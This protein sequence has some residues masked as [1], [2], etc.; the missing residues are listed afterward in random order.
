PLPAAV[1]EG[2][3]VMDL[4]WIDRDEVARTGLH[5]AAPAVGSLR[6]AGDQADAELVVRVAAER[7]PRIG[8]DGFGAG[9]AARYAPEVPARHL[10]LS[11]ARGHRRP[12]RP[13]RPP[14]LPATAASARR[15]ASRATTRPP[16][17]P[18]GRQSLHCLAL[19]RQ[20]SRPCRHRRY[21]GSPAWAG[22]RPRRRAR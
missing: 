6:A 10:R 22:N 7:A 21:R 20:H 18:I 2:A 8:L 17:R 1:A 5:H 15:R 14:V 12:A 4:A 3:A 11:L 9:D 16:G 19:W 13:R